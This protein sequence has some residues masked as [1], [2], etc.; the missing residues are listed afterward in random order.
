MIKID[1][2]KCIGCLSCTD[3]CVCSSIGIEEGR[4]VYNVEMGCIKCMHCA[5]ACPEN[6]ITFDGKPAVFSE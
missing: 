6:A 1:Y 4:P 2:D 3:K 5:I